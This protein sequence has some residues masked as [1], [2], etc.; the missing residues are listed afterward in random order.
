MDGGRAEYESS[1]AVTGLTCDKS[2]PCKDTALA[3]P[4]DGFFR[5]ANRVNSS[6][7]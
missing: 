7:Y 5:E 1:S 4:L 6:S 2:Q 3:P